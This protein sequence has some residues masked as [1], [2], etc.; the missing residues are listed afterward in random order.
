VSTRACLITNPQSGR[1]GVDLSDVLLVLQAN[2]WKVEVRQKLEGGQAT[3]LA[4]QAAH[5]GFD[6]VCNCGGDGTMREIISGLVNTEVA[7]GEIPGGTANVW[8]RE[9][10]IS[11]QL[12]VAATQLVNSERLRVDVGQV[13][14]NDHQRAY[15]LLMAGLGLD[16]A[17]IGRVS[18]SLKNRIGPLAVGLAAL[19]TIPSVHTVPVRAEFDGL[20]WQGA[21]SQIIV[22]NT[23]RYGGFTRITSGAYINDGLLD[24]CFFTAA[25]PVQAGR[26]VTSLLLRQRPSAAGSESYRA[27]TVTIHTP[28]VLPLQLDGGAV[29]QKPGEATSE[30]TV[31]R[32]SLLPQA[33]TMLMPRTYDGELFETVP[34]NDTPLHENG[35]G[36][37]KRKKGKKGKKHKDGM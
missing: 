25:G 14:I 4:R 28:V 12:R 1:G 11:R 29:K 31:Y 22:G 7:I 16:G 23:R 32:F 2:G 33:V 13:S 26:Q 20:H 21:V 27:A 35:S 18:D 8:S 5:D 10:G 15:F 6:V 19:E 9:L 34:L 36:K 24:V 17:V 3:D 30:G 37:T